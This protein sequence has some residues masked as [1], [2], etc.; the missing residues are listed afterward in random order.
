[1]P[2]REHRRLSMTAREVPSATFSGTSVGLRKMNMREQAS[3]EKLASVEGRR[4]LIIVENLPVPFDRRVWQEARALR[5]AGASVSII[6]PTGK[7]Y[8]MREEVIDGVKVYRHPLPIDASSAMGYLREY[9]S[10]LLWETY[11]SWKVF[12]RDGFDAIHA[13]NPPDLIFLIALQFKIFGKKF[14]FDHHDINPELYEAKFKRRDG[15]W[16]LM[17]LLERMTFGLADVS[18]ATN[19]SY[20]R[21]AI[22]RGKMKPDDVFVVRSGPDLSRIRP[23][24][25]APAWR[26]GR[27][28]LVGYVG[29]IGA[30]EG[31]DLLLDAA[32][33]IVH[34]LGRNDIQF[35]IVGGGPALD[36][37]KRT[38]AENGLNDFVTFL[39]RAPDADLLEV[40]STS[41]VCVNPDRVNEMNSLS[42]MNKVLEYMAL[43][44]PIVQFEVVEGR[45]SAQGAS[46][47]ARANDP[48]DFADKIVELLSNDEGRRLM[49]QMGR[50]RVETSLS[51][52]HQVPRLI[53]AYQRL[54]R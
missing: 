45:V 22:E 41:D 51:W 11:L 19:D 3:V 21:I 50:E 49:G 48:R 15:F 53:E 13:C 27:K 36:D 34:E 4:I 1:M 52:S 39:G 47:Y 2:D 30:Q 8:E 5:D 23:V 35:C 26:N 46:L 43:G 16:R 37:L 9:T 25:I 32:K 38:A 54:F 10:A 44:K 40:L 24:A 28:Y 6:C 17:L 29:V 20:R 33:H 31:V 12:F 42:T 18:I 14:V 7:G